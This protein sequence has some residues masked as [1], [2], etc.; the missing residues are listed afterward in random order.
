VQEGGFAVDDSIDGALL[1]L[2]S[3]VLELAA[4]MQT[5]HLF[6]RSTRA[7]SAGR[8]LQAF[9]T[10]IDAICLVPNTRAHS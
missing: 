10:A 3:P 5:L 7:H 2:V 8:V 9:G 4:N 1:P 6:A